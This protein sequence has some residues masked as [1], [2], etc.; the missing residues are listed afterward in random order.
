MVLQWLSGGVL[1]RPAGATIKGRDRTLNLALHLPDANPP[2]DP[3]YSLGSCCSE[4]K[5]VMKNVRCHASVLIFRN[6]SL[7]K[8]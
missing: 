2:S 7:F 1:N 6:N 4:E 5:K 3:T 8:W